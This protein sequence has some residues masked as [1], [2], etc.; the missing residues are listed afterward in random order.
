MYGR[1]FASTPISLDAHDASLKL[2]RLSSST[3]INIDL[4]GETHAALV[5]EKQRD[6]VKNQLIHVDFQVVSLTEKIRT[7]V[8]IHLEGVSPAV[9]DFNGV[10]VT[11]LDEVEVESLPQ[12]LPER[13]TV[14]I[15][16]LAR[17]GDAIHVRDLT[18]ASEVT[19][20]EDMDEI[21][22]VISA[23]KEEEIEEAP[24]TTELVEPE[25]IERGKK[26]EEEI[27]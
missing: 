26:E 12:Y 8:S 23:T 6:Y 3:I 24:V 15:S 21:V 18:V 22:V 16:G 19:I 17:I 11:N 20:L 1:H 9:K 25:V 4:D 10:V 27:E 14:D 2:A 7:T 5:R 13:I